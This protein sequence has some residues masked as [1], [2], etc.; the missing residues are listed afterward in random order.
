METVDLFR[1]GEG[2]EILDQAELQILKDASVLQQAFSDG[3]R[4]HLLFASSTDEGRLGMSNISV[5]H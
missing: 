1:Q 5:L 2:E 3:K 4:K